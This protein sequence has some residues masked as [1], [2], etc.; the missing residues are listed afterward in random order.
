MDYSEDWFYLPE[1]LLPHTAKRR[2]ERNRAKPGPVPHKA[3]GVTVYP[4]TTGPDLRL[5]GK[6]DKSNSRVTHKGPRQATS[7]TV[8]PAITTGEFLL[9]GSSEL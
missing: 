3:K 8:D 2:F 4:Q 7:K 9:K 1:D 5:S 6:V